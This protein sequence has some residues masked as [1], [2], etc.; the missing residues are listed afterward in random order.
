MVQSLLKTAELTKQYDKHH[1]RLVHDAITRHYPPIPT[2]SRVESLQAT[3][4]MHYLET[5]FK[6]CDNPIRD[7]SV[8]SPKPLH[9][10]INR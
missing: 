7:N 6:K 1:R 2:P 4:H 10:V 9:L 8:L 5:T 3:R